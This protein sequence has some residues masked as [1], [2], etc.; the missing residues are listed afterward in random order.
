M[1]NKLF[2]GGLSWDTTDAS[3]N[4][5][6]SKAGTVISANVITDKFT[7][8]SRGFG[9]VEM[10]SDEESEKAKSELNGQS[11]DSRAISVNDAKPPEQRDNNFQRNFDRRDSRGG[12]DRRRSY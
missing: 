4:E 5:F 9:F 11:L 7:G 6:F 2:V 1:A 8:K 12:G 3:L 10:S